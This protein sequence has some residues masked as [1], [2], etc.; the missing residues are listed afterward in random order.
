[1]KVRGFLQDASIYAVPTL[2]TRALGLIL[3]PIYARYLSPAE[4]GVVEILTIAY[5][6]LN[7]LLPLEVSQA[8]ARLSA[9]APSAARRNV[10]V[11]TA[12][13]FTG[14]VF[15]AFVVATWIAPISVRDAVLG[16]E[17]A[18]ETLA[19]ASLWMMANA[20]FYVV[21]NQ[22][23][24]DRRSRAYAGTSAV[25]AIV[26]AGVSVVLIAGFGSGVYGY[27]WGQLA[28]SLAGFVTGVARLRP[29]T[30]VALLLDTAELKHML[31]F[32]APLVL[33]SIAAYLALYV[34]RWLLFAWRGGTEMGVY[35]V[36]Y[37]IASIVTL[38]VAVVQLALTPMIYAHH[39]SPETPPALRRIFRYFLL[40]TCS[41]VLGVSAFAPE[42]VSL[43]ASATYQPAAAP[44]PWLCLGMVLANVYLFAPGLILAKRTKTIAALSLAA[45]GVNIAVSASLIPVLGATG[46][47]LGMLAA[48]GASA[49][50]YLW[51]GE[52][53]YRISY[54]WGRCA[55][56]LIAVPAILLFQQLALGWRVAL[57]LSACAV[58]TLTLLGRRDIPWLDT[59]L[60]SPRSR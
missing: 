36:A 10:Y 28:G 26:T 2:L 4:Y 47:A 49:T 40:G 13:S 17:I 46:A 23:R 45:A 8:V 14:I 16:S 35:A 21:L 6:L 12:L 37:R 48:S 60:G 34:D 9:D 24:W 19:L 7:L 3:L 52:R 15:L 29:T 57:L 27:L 42:I 31:A 59:R 39:Q 43:L 1:M 51:L 25:F 32:S 30:R 41:L 22:L 20:L 44:V 56:V 55:V 38:A 33:S 18:G 58:M 5:V 11:S 53:H 50:L 54:E